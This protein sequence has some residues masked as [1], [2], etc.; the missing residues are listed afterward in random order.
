M[1]FNLR[2]TKISMKQKLA[3][4]S[5]INRLSDSQEAQSRINGGW[6]ANQITGDPIACYAGLA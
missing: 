4:S 3:M 6:G 5:S 2:W 1:T